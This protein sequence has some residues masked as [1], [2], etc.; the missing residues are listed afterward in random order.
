MK[1]VINC[2]K[3]NSSCYKTFIGILTEELPDGSKKVI[4]DMNRDLEERKQRLEVAECTD[5]TTRR[6]KQV[7]GSTP[8][9][10]DEVP[11][12]ELKSADRSSETDGV[13][14]PIQASNSGKG[15]SAYVPNPPET[16][17]R[18]RTLQLALEMIRMAD[19]DAMQD[20]AQLLQLQQ[21]NEELKKQRR[22][23]KNAI[24]KEK[25]LTQELEGERS[26]LKTL[27][28]EKEQETADLKREIEAL[29]IRLSGAEAQR[30]TFNSKCSK[31]EQEL[32]SLESEYNTKIANKRDII[33]R[34][35]KKLEHQELRIKKTEPTVIE[36]SNTVKELMRHNHE[37]DK[38]ILS[39]QEKLNLWQKESLERG[40]RCSQLTQVVASWLLLTLLGLLIVG[41]AIYKY[42]KD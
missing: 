12:P 1:A 20:E 35:E 18:R 28:S 25:K 42:I 4:D 3:T 29:K 32:S 41:V 40:H 30:N 8:P 24:E 34:L 33:K 26:S 13:C 15:E 22:Q 14:P 7:T 39:L 23:L 19:S 27:M 38:E 16:S 31:L 10:V 9:G 37:K 11:R 5:D 6:K 36:L 17:A 21:E 2:I